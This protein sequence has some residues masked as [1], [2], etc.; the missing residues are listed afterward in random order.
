ME[1]LD[2]YTDYAY[3]YIETIC[4]DIGPRFSCSDEE[5]KANVWIESELSKYCDSTGIDEF[6]AHPKF[7]IQGIFRV[8]FP[9]GILSYLLNFLV[10]PYY[11]LSSL[12]M[13][14][15]CFIL[16]SD[17][18][19]LKGLI[20]PIFKKKSST[21]AYGIVKPKKEVKFRVILDG[22]TDSAIELPWARVRKIS[23][24]I[25]LVVFA[26]MF[27]LYNLVYPITELIL[28]ITSSNHMIEYS[29][30]IFEIS[31]M[32]IIGLSIGFVLFLIFIGLFSGLISTRKVMGANDNL[33]GSAIAATAAKYFSKNRLDNIE[34][35][36]LST[37]SEEIGE[38]GAK[39]FA[40]KHP[41]LFENAYSLAI[42]CVGAGKDLF[43]VEKDY[44][45]LAD[46]SQEVV[47]RVKTA[48]DD[49]KQENPDVI[50]CQIGRLVIGSSNANIYIK[51]GYKA[52]F[53]I[54]QSEDAP[55]RPV[56]WHGRDDTFDKIDK[57]VLNDILGI[58]ITFVENVDKEFSK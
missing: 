29:W 24:L 21:N 10:F 52:A 34:L 28:Q 7:F 32:D 42:E 48:Y 57:K 25:F 27:I 1:K 44:F 47:T 11:I 20:R 45:H 26:V 56:H 58:T 6:Q 30:G 23:I 18:V 15:A 46:Y 3:S 43:I 39:D 19:M 4:N 5:R 36:V 35:V 41:E 22:H 37:G 55:W 9:L 38:R 12:I 40:E 49:Y 17:L 31:N 14:I 53:I 8:V 54:V 50:S 33:S 51:K 16:I 13:L 2:E